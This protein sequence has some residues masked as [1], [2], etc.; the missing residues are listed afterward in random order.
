MSFLHFFISTFPISYFLVPSFSSTPHTC[1]G[2]PVR[3]LLNQERGN[4]NIRNAEMKKW[5]NELQMAFL[6]HPKL[7]SHRVID[8]TVAVC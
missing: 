3:V 5:R 8:N 6:D 7:I 2:G 1:P 4:K